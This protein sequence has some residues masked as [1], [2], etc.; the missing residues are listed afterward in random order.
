VSPLA[1]GQVAR[2]YCRNKR[3]VV[4]FSSRNFGDVVFVEVGA[5]FSGSIVHDF[6]TGK[7]V[8]RGQQLG[9]FMPGGS[10]L[11]M[12]FKKDAFVPDGTIIAQTEAGFE[13]RIQVGAPLGACNV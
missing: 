9:H 12:F 8:K 4:S 5:T 2:L 7:P 6:E 10:L 1:L 3:A 11:L 13:S